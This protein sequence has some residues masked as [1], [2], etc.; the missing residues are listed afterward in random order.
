MGPHA[1]VFAMRALIRSRPGSRP[2]EGEGRGEPQAGIALARMTLGEVADPQ[3]APH[4]AL[5]RVRAISLNRGECRRLAELPEGSSTGW[6]LAGEVLAPAA[7]GSGPQQGSRVVGLVPSGAWAQ[8]AAVDVDWL[9]PLPASVSFAQGATLPVAGLTALKALD[10]IGSVLA[11]RV[12][13]TGANGGVGR[14]ALQLAHLAGAHVLALASSPERAAGLAELGA[15][16]LI[17]DLD[18]SSLE[19]DAIIEGVGGATLGSAIEHVAPWGCVVCFASSDPNPVSFP[20]RSLFARAPGA[21]VHGLFL[22]ATLAR[23]GGAG[24][25][26]ARLLKLL[27]AGALR[28]PIAQEI[29]WE[30]ADG[31]IQA[32]MERRIAGKVILHVD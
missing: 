12:L 26:L 23:C 25:E 3:P 29:G 9:A 11:R 17:Y 32:L 22:F 27:E 8:L 28:C 16:E 15:D 4:Q 2:G 30:H 21:S 10:L 13:V 24:P 31:A 20:T 1:S 6:D 14:F 7:D 5:V 19:L 18:R